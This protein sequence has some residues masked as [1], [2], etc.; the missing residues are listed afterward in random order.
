MNIRPNL[1]KTFLAVAHS[2]SF[3][4]A[5]TDVHLAQSSVSDQIQLLE[6]DLGTNLFVRSKAGLELTPAGAVLKP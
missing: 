4:R 5:A 1:L 3:T 2:R 6:T